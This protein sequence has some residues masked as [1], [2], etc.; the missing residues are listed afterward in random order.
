MCLYHKSWYFQ[1]MG[2][3][4]YVCVWC[5]LY[6]HHFSVSAKSRQTFSYNNS[7]VQLT[8]LPV[9]RNWV[10]TVYRQNKS[11]EQSKREK[12]EWD[13]MRKA[14]NV[15]VCF[16]TMNALNCRSIVNHLS[17]VFSLRCSVLT[18]SFNLYLFNCW[19][20]PVIDFNDISS[21]RLTNFTLSLSISRILVELMGAQPLRLIR[22][23]RFPFGFEWSFFQNLNAI[24]VVSRLVIERQCRSCHC[25][26][27]A[28]KQ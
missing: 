20:E 6:N 7:I 19:N 13:T 12:E 23:L 22:W 26:S 9:C 24:T 28:T 4:V 1:S 17:C 2:E 21:I 10:R 8:S 5:R 15:I 16:V 11:N 14:F 25:R 27:S 18:Y 3:T